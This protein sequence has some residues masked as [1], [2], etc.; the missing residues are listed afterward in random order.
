[1]ELKQAKSQ[2]A[3]MNYMSAP[4]QYPKDYVKQIKNIDLSPRVNKNTK[5]LIFDNDAT[6]RS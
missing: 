4:S 5:Q 3:K 2:V 6:R 1:M